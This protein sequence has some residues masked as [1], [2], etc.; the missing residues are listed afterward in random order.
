MALRRCAAFLVILLTACGGDDGAAT[1][2]AAIGPDAADTPDAP[3]TTLPATCEGACRTL[4]LTATFN[5]NTRG[6]D[7]AFY[8]FTLGRLGSRLYLEASAG[9]NPGCPTGGGRTPDRTFR[10]DGLGVPTSTAPLDGAGAL[11]D[12]RG[13][14]LPTAPTASADTTTATPVAGSLCQECVGMPAP[15]DPD[16]FIA[17]DIQSTFT[18][19]APGTVAGHVYAT[20]CDS[21][22]SVE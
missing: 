6:F 12:F 9:G 19:S 2:D 1:P 3:E 14:L 11:L 7:R 4:A 21:L 16:G 17:L 22:D 15:S 13:D 18:G 8:G 5:G 20:H 10:V